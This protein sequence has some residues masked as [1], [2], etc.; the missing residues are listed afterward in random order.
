MPSSIPRSE[1]ALASATIAALIVPTAASGAFGKTA[2]LPDIS[3]T[4][5]FA[6]FSAGQAACAVQ[7]ERQA[8]LPLLVRHL[9][10][11]DLWYR[12]GDVEQR[13]DSIEGLQSLIDHPLGG[14]RLCSRLARF[15][16]TKTNAEKSRARRIAVA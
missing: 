13:V 11:I 7:L 10:Q 6:C 14:R 1:K 4:A 8:G 16:A 3:T 12:A 15:R 2:E 5:P 9:E